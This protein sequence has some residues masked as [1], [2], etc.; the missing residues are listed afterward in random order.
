MGAV[1]G[2]CFVGVAVGVW[3]WIAE[4]GIERGRRERW[5][6]KWSGVGIQEKA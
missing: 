5:E 2:L 6:G 3:G 1:L 4:R